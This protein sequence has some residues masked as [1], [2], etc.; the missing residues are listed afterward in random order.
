MALS[1]AVLYLHG[2][3]GRKDDVDFIE[4]DTPTAV[5]EVTEESFSAIPSKAGRKSEKA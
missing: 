5:T 2:Q 1:E 3:I 4:P